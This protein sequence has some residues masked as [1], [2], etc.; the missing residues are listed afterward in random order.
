MGQAQHFYCFRAVIIMFFF[1]K[2]GTTKNKQKKTLD[3]FRK[4]DYKVIVATTIAEEGI[5]VKE[6]NLV[7]RYN[8]AGNII[9]QIQ[10]KG[11]F[12][13]FYEAVFIHNI[14]IF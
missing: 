8:Y 9:S 12:P 3:L 4:G 14:C 6:C 13:I 11:K 1:S 10:A 7:V 2:T 5:D